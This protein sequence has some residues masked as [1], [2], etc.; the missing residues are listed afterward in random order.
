MPEECVI[1]EVYEELGLSIRNPRLYGLLMFP[2]D[3]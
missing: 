2:T 1:R 3:F